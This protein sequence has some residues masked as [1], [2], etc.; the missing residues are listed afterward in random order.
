MSKKDKNQRKIEIRNVSVMIAITLLA[1]I[2]CLGFY[3]TK[4][5]N[6]YMKYNESS[7]I[8]Y[9]VLLKENEF[10]KD[11]YL[12]QNKGYI[13]S[14]IDSIASEFK[15]RISFSE[16]TNYNYSYKIILEID[17]I[18]TTNNSNLYH[19]SEDLITKSL[20]KNTGDLFIKEDLD[21]KYEEYNNLISKFKDIY[22]LKNVESSLNV[23]LYVTIQDID[24]SDTLQFVDKKVSSLKIPLT[25]NTVSIDIGNETINHKSHKIELTEQGS[26]FWALVIGLFYFFISAVYIIYLVIYT[27]KTRTAQM[28]YEKEIKSI[29]NNYAS[30]IQKITG[31]YDIGTSQVLK[32]ETFTDMLEIRDTLKQPILMLENKA[33]DGTFFIIPATNSL[34]YTY[35][36]RVVDI[37]AKMDGKEVPTYDITEISHEKFMKNKKYTD[38]Y[39]KDQITMTKL[40]PSIDEKNIIKGNKDKDRDLYNQLEMTSSFDVKEIRRALKKTEKER[41]S[42]KVIKKT[43][44]K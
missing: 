28:I 10:F 4:D 42:K 21:I 16:K 18:D 8:D 32:I 13:A 27:K 41:K 30:Y 39:I 40:M 9:K 5:R 19:L 38:K 23:Y 29:M 31:S 2:F 11:Q 6:H 22:E 1:G 35:A 17:V 20:T 3:L 37:K 7:E 14:L 43:L 44:D 26:H 25:L 24:R 36:L 33:K 15:Y 12:E 34:I